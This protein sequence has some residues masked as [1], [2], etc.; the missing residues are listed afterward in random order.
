VVH[1]GAFDVDKVLRLIERR[2][3]TN[4]GAVPTL[5]TNASLLNETLVPILTD[6]ALSPMN[7]AAVYPAT[8]RQGLKVKALVEFLAERLGPEPAWDV[9]LI[10][11]GW[12]Q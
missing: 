10:E 2:K 1:Q 12:V 4:W 11:R 6:Y 7:F 5:I 9:P 3:V 8:Q